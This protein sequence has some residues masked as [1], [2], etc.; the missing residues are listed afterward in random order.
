[1][2][3]P[4]AREE[5]EVPEGVSV[6][7]RSLSAYDYEVRVKGPMGELKKVIK[8]APVRIALV[9]STVVFEVYNARKREYAQ[10]GALKGLLKNMILGVTRGWRYKLLVVY[11]HFP[12]IVKVEGRRLIIENFL[13]RKSRIVLE[14]PEGV[15]VEASKEEVIVEG[16]DRDKVSGFAAMIESATMLRGDERPSSH[17]REG[18][19]GVLDGIYVYHIGHIR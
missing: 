4:Y 19:P 14:I 3:V 6:E 10:L 13:G 8:N 17:G 2:R 7:V 11:T 12:T 18:G 9:D 1:M 16:I 5:L 15:K